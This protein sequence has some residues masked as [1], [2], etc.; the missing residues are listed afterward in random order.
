MLGA[1]GKTFAFNPEQRDNIFGD[2]GSYAK[3]VVCNSNAQSAS[4][5]TR[6]CISK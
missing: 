1:K 5:S 6:I 3:A 2:I 4:T